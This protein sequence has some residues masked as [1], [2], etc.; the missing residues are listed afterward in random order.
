MSF[1][2]Y[3]IDHISYGLRNKD[4]DSNVDSLNVHIILCGTVYWQI[5]YLSRRYSGIGQT[6]L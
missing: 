4:L 1:L 5:D 3:I 6:I 2:K